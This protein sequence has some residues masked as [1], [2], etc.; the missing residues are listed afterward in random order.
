MEAG[1][2]VIYIVGHS[3]MEGCYEHILVHEREFSKEEFECTVNS[4]LVGI[5][6]RALKGKDPIFMDDAM[7]RVAHILRK[8]HGFSTPRFVVVRYSWPLQKSIEWAVDSELRKAVSPELLDRVLEHNERTW[9]RQTES[10]IRRAT[11][12][13]G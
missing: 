11:A 12:G 10:D 4:V 8:K 13:E 9:R 5:F 2:P 7:D 6:K 1:K 3:D